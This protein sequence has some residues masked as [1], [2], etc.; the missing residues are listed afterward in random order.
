MLFLDQVTGIQ[1]PPPHLFLDAIWVLDAY[2][3][4]LVLD[5]I[6]TLSIYTRYVYVC[7]Y[8]LFWSIYPKQS[9]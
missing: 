1:V 2:M 8:V 6:Y 3:R 7:T 5:A 9:T 4:D